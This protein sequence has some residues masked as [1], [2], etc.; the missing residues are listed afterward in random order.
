MS[1]NDVL[2]N[3][4]LTESE[5][6]GMREVLKEKNLSRQ[7]DNRIC[8]C[9]HPINYHRS[10]VC[11]PA[12][13]V[14]PCQNAVAVLSCDDTRFFLRKTEGPGALHALTRGIVALTVKGKEAEWIDTPVCEYPECES[15]EGT[16]VIPVPI[17]TTVVPPRISYGPTKVN[18]FLCEECRMK[19][20]R[21]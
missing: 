14:C 10:G 21:L 5:L 17:N 20:E 6:T 19:L 2:N 1:T 13:M 16:K 18:K 8:I 9:G 7:R 15:P 11:M 3:L 4:G 12:K